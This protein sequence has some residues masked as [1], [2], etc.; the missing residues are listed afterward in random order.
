MS[1]PKDAG[2]GRSDFRSKLFP[3]GYSRSARLLLEPLQ[4]SDAYG[5]IILTNDPLVAHGAS[6]LPQPF[7]M[8]DARELIA[9]PH[10]DGGCFAALRL[11]EGGEMIGCAGIVAREPEKGDVGDLELGF[12]LGAPYH[13]HR[14]GAEA[15]QTMLELAQ[16]A[17]PQARIVVEC[18]RVNGASWR[19]LQRLGFAPGAGR[20]N[21]MNAE[22]LAWRASAEVD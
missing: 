16:R 13:G 17:F 2:A 7:T 3:N 4:A 14:Y 12:W 21:R 5:L 9:L 18:P 20:G 11:H 1:A 15:A 8:D 6:T 19:L 22:L 10:H